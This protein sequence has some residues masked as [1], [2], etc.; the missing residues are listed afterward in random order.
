M[1]GSCSDMLLVV[2]A[3]LGRRYSGLEELESMKARQEQNSGVRCPGGDSARLKTV[4]HLNAGNVAMCISQSV[5]LLKLE[6][7]RRGRRPVLGD[8]NLLL[9]MISAMS[10]MRCKSWVG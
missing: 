5:I 8:G 10:L 2:C 1:L 9:S 7:G 6:G 4:S 3:A